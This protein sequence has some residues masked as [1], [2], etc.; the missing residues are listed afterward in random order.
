MRIVARE[1][2]YSSWTALKHY[3]E[4]LG[5]A[6]YHLVSDHEAYRQTITDSYDRRSVNYDNSQW[7]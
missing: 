5:F 3:I 6:D 7:H 4:S 2:G 1:Y